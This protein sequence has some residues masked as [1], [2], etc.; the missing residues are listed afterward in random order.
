MNDIIC[1]IWF[2]VAGC[3]LGSFYNV[4]IDRLPNDQDVLKDR[5]KCSYCG[6]VLKWKDLIPVFSYIFLRGRCRY[7]KEKLSPQYLISEISVGALFLL[8]YLLFIQVFSVP[9]LIL[10]LSFWSML[11]I[12]AVMD[13]KYSI[14]MDQILIPFT[15]IGVVTQL[16]VGKQV[17]SLTLPGEQTI[18]FVTRDPWQMFYGALAGLIFYGIVYLTARLIYKKE[19]FGFGDVLLL[20]AIGIF[21]GLSQTIITG[22]M[23]FYLAIVFMLIFKLVKKGSLKDR[24]IPFAPPLCMAAFIMSIYGG[25]IEYWL[26]GLMGI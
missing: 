21:M 19:A 7:C 15:L 24:P 14:I 2:F 6:T 12:V 8:A 25:V 11:Y 1:G 23:A 4:L 3:A 17:F 16:I 13:F 18:E 22:F 10:R 5:S 20:G 9:T 26:R